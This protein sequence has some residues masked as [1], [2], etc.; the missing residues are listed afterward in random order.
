MK[1]VIKIIALS[2]IIALLIALGICY[3]TMPE[4]TKE[5]AEVV[6]KFLNTPV[7]I[8]GGTT[9][10]VGIVIGLIIK[11]VYDRYRNNVRNE[12]NELK[13]EIYQKDREAHENYVNAEKTREE[14]L[15]ILSEYSQH[16]DYSTENLI[17]VCETIPNAKI[18]AIG[19]EINEHKFDYQ[20]K[21]KENLFN[22]EEQFYA[23]EQENQSIESLSN[24]LSELQ[25]HIERL[26]QKYGKK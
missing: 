9:I 15:S 16:L 19:K 18:K 4:R 1:K 23:K 25:S 5:A 11:L 14:I 26:E 10:T 20:Q 6:I 17:K 3:F 12:I 21:V 22:I 24:Q 13:K 7:G 8:I 2:F